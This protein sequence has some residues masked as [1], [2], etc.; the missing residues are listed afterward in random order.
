MASFFDDLPTDAGWPG[1]APMAAAAVRDPAAAG[2]TSIAEVLRDLAP[3][4]GCHPETLRQQSQ[5]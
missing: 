4:V 5:V 1:W 3:R 2:F